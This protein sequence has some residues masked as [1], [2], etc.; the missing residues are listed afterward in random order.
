ME[1]IDLIQQQNPRSLTYDSPDISNM[2]PLQ[3]D[4]RT[5]FYFRSK[6]RRQAFISKRYN[7]KTKKFNL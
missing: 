5:T 7:R 2:F 4:D 3:V 6:E 1:K